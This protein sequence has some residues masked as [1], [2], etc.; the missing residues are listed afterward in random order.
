MRPTPGAV[1]TAAHRLAAT[2]PALLALLALLAVLLTPTL[3]AY[4][5]PGAGA[6]PG[7][8]ATAERTSVGPGRP[9]DTAATPT[10]PDPERADD[11][12]RA[13]DPC[14]VGCVP[15]LRTRHP[16]PAERPSPPDH[17]TA[18][19]R[20]PVAPAAA[21]PHVPAPSACPPLSPGRP[22]HD[23]VRAPPT[24]SGT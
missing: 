1:P 7:P 18:G 9:P 12:P 14:A 22:A 24:A 17:H 8:A 6:L 5:G 19:P 16:H 2:F 3:P 15:Q 13:D 4:A 10:T 20:G 21:R 11:S 23:R